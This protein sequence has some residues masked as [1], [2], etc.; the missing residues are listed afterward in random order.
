MSLYAPRLR[1]ANTVLGLYLIGSALILPLY[2]ASRI[3]SVLCG[4]IVVACSLLRGRF[5]ERGTPATR[6]TRPQL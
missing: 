1:Y 5:S 6:P 3:N 4:V 2:E